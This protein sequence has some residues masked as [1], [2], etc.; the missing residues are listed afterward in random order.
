[1]ENVSVT[2]KNDSVF[3]SQCSE[4]NISVGLTS[5]D[6]QMCTE[7]IV[8]HKKR[9]LKCLCI[10]LRQLFFLIEKMHKKTFVQQLNQ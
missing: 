5:N 6:L 7:H 8:C 4:T 10:K 2:E 9:S 3:F 1:M